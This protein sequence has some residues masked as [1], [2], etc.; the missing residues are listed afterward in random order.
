MSYLR[1]LSVRFPVSSVLR[2]CRPIVARSIS[3]SVVRLQDP[4]HTYCPCGKPEIVCRARSVLFCI[5]VQIWR[6]WNKFI[7]KA[8]NVMDSP[9]FIYPF[10]VVAGCCSAGLS[11]FLAIVA[12]AVL[13][14]I[15]RRR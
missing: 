9:W 13:D 6:K 2:C 1:A 10:A 5:P 14:D 3:L 4:K 12:L 8:V 15:G 7:D 11:I